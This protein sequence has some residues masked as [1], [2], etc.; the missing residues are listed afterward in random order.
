MESSKVL[1]GNGMEGNHYLKDFIKYSSLNVLGMVAL[2]CYILADTF[3]VS[4]GMGAE[5]LAALNLAIPVFSFIHG[6]GLMLGMGGAIRYSICRGQKETKNADG[7]F[8][9]VIC[10]TAVFALIFFCAGLFLSGGIARMLGAD[11]QVFGMTETYLR[12]LL[13]FSPA[14]LVNDVLI[15]F[16][17]NDGD[18]GRAMFAMTGGSLS[19]ILLDYIFIFPL[20]MGIFGAVLAT[21][22]AP[23]ISMVILSPHWVKKRNQFHFVKGKPSLRWTRMILSLGF[24]SLVT[25]V[26]SGIVIIVFNTI[27][28]NL[29]GN[30][31]IA[32]YGVIANLSLVVLA[33]FTGVAQGIQPLVSRACGYNQQEGSRKMLRYGIITVA[34]LSGLIYLVV[35]W[36]AGPI[37]EVF[38]SGKNLQLQE[39]AVEGLRLYFTATFFAGF[40]I[41]LAT[42]FS[43]MDQAVPAQVI[44]LCRGIFLIVPMAFL[45]SACW[46]LTGVWLAFPVTECFVA[47][48]ACVLK[49]KYGSAAQAGN[50]T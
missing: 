33:V 3:F 50:Q 43:A 29:Q 20:N 6:S 7:I 18:P 11:T 46:G 44:S 25:E 41:V 5:G 23:V 40:N 47:V 19:N 16:V 10:L 8:T 37:A 2:S 31:G 21:G 26:S 24:P 38:N 45:L 13:L 34:V 9:N 27:I 28:L 17:R 36:F 14:F 42:Y 12:V 4:K 32:A 48:L 15:C 1:R 30:V 22:F 35:F 49:R 39:I